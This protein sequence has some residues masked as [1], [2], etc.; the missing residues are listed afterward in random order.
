MADKDDQFIPKYIKSA[1]WYKEQEGQLDNLLDPLAHQRINPNEKPKD[2]SVAYKGRGAQDN[3]KKVESGKIV[4]SQGK[5]RR[6]AGCDNCGSLQH[7]RSECLEKPKKIGAKYAKVDNEPAAEFEI[8]D[9]KS[10]INYEA[11]RDNYFGYD[12]NSWDNNVSRYRQAERVKQAKLVAAKT[13][14]EECISDD[15]ALELLELGLDGSGLLYTIK[16]DGYKAPGEKTVRLLEDRA[17]YL[18]GVNLQESLDDDDVHGDARNGTSAANANDFVSELNGEAA[19]FE[20]LRLVSWK[21]SIGGEGKPGLDMH[22][23]PTA[24]LLQIKEKKKASQ[25]QSLANKKKLLDRYG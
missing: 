15:E 6:G 4:S 17:N 21:A 16:K 8:R 5:K 10:L 9:E 1:P 19:E 24:V 22:T 12:V 13:K 7:K 18:N 11:K 25:E 3:F 20:K 14:H 2:F 23:T